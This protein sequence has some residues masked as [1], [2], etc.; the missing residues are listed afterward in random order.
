MRTPATVTGGASVGTLAQVDDVDDG[1]G[2]DSIDTPY[3]PLNNTTWPSDTDL[4]FT[5][6]TNKVT[7]TVQRPLIRLVAQDGFENLRASLLFEN[8]FPDASD[9]PAIIQT[10]LTDAAESLGPKATYIHKRLLCDVEYLA[11]LSCLVSCDE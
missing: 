7:L 5:P 2:G 6:G 9:S 10:A 11:K 3:T 1:S 8:A 4:I